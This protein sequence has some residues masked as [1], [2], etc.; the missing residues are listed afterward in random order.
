MWK[1]GKRERGTRGRKG[2]GG[3]RAPPP[4]RYV[5]AG[6]GRK[7]GPLRLW[8]CGTPHRGAW[9]LHCAPRLRKWR[10][11][12]DRVTTSVTIRADSVGSCEGDGD[13]AVTCE[14]LCRGHE[15]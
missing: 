14:R 15:P 10:N 12:C 2:P 1:G 9:P 11:A 3:S 6:P 13:L 5:P 8:R 4:P 7:G